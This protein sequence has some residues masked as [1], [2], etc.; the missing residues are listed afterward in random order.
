VLLGLD[1]RFDVFDQDRHFLAISSAKVSI[2]RFAVQGYINL[3][4]LRVE[5]TCNTLRQF[6]KK[7]IRI[8]FPGIIRI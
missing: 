6:I 4:I 3:V 2:F 7:V 5:K 8:P 1:D